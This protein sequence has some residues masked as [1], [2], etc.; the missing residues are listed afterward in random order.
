MLLPNFVNKTSFIIFSTISIFLI[1]WLL[2]V[3][4]TV[5]KSLP[6]PFPYHSYTLRWRGVSQTLK[7]L[8][9]PQSCVP[10]SERCRSLLGWSVPVRAPDWPRC[11]SSPWWSSP[12]ISQHG[13]WWVTLNSDNTVELLLEL[14]SHWEEIL[15]SLPLIIQSYAGQELGKT[16]IYCLQSKDYGAH[17]D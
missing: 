8:S 7:V 14:P 17:K 3:Y 15:S 6:T 12:V 10:Q 1:F 9:S 4:N 13:E 16:Y 2:N 11:S 5:E